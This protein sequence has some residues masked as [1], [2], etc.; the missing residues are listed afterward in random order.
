[1]EVTFN[2][3]GYISP[4]QFKALEQGYPYS[5]PVI[6]LLGHLLMLHKSLSLEGPD[7]I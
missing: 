3:L 7:M 5:E 2:C 6:Y 4:L 1:M